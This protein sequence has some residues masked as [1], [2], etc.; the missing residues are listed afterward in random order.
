M[1]SR[2]WLARAGAGAALAALCVT[3]VAGCAAPAPRLLLGGI[4]A[5][6]SAPDGIRVL[7]AGAD[8]P[9]GTR[10]PVGTVSP[11]GIVSPA[12]GASPGSAARRWLRDGSVPGSTPVLRQMAA[13]A[14]VDLRLLTRP[15]GAVAAA[16]YGKWKFAWPRDDSWAAAAFAATGHPGESL[17]VLRFLARVQYPSGRWAAKYTLSGTPVVTG[18]G[19]ELDACGWFPWAVW[20]WYSYGGGRRA[21]R[22]RELAGL[23]PAVRL[24]ADA[25]AASLSRGGL[26]PP[27]PDYWEDRT[28]QPTIGTAG[29]LLAGL[30]A[31][32]RLATGLRDESDARRWAVAAARLDRG[33]RTAYGPEFNRFPDRTGGQAEWL[34]LFG[35]GAGPAGGG[36]AGGGLAD[37]GLAGGGQPGAWLLNGPDAAVTF[38]GPPFGP[39]DAAVNAAVARAARVLT[40][41]NG[42][43]LAG[44]TWRGDRSVAWTPATGFFAL[45]DA[46]TGRLDAARTWLNWLAAHRTAAGALPEQVSAS[47]QPVSVAPLDWTCAIVLLAL[48]AMR[49]PLPI[50]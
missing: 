19:S 46:S 50:P 28:S 21:A 17:R 22:R 27:S 13:G 42:G 16:W 31:A 6:Q 10:F 29:P 7:P 24:A 4:T 41:P 35:D 33:I 5:D 12:A 15:D 26:P 3:A 36:A 40:L 32:V 39:P 37:G 30:H 38:L 18:P 47:G 20:T 45:Y 23:W 14:L 25:T 11:A 48:T 44:T 49:H 1:S 9:A 2:A 34:A 43:I 8:S